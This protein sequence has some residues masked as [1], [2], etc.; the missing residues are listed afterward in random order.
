MIST[1]RGTNVRL[2]KGD[3]LAHVAI[4]IAGNFT[5]LP[6]AS[7]VCLAWM[8]KQLKDENYTNPQYHIFSPLDAF[9]APFPFAVLHGSRRA[10][11]FPVNMKIT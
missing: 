10:F 9:R 5:L 2:A 4:A 7:I 6:N 8:K 3:S 11:V 1:T